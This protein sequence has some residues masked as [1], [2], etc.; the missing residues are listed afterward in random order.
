MTS[1][2]QNTQR[3]VF[4]YGTLRAG[5]ANDIN[6]LQPTPRFVTHARLAGTMYHLGGYPGVLLGGKQTVL[7]E[8]YAIDAALERVLD[9]IEEI[10]PQ[11]KDEYTKREITVTVPNRALPCLVY[12]IN[13]RYVENR[14]QI[15]GG[16]WVNR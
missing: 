6:R 8:V 13:A 14:P 5:Q 11:R 9:E 10:Y 16:D 3:H 1:H 2:P 12:E 15:A 4:V 7:G